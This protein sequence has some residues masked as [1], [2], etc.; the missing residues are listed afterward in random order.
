MRILY[1]A[2]DQR[3]PGTVGGS[4]HVR[5]V[6]EG[7]AALG[8]DVHVAYTPGGDPP[9]SSGV[10]WHAMPPPFGE[11]RFRMALAPRVTRLARTLRPD[12]VVERYHNFGG[13]GIWAALTVGVPS[14]L[15]VNA[16]VV[17]HPGSWKGRLDRAAVFHPLRRWREWQCR[18]AA[19]IVTPT[20]AI[21]P[22]WL[23]AGR[24]LTIEWGA[25][26]ARFHPDAAGR[27]PF[28]RDRGKVVAIFAGAFRAWH[29]AIHLV[30]AI[31]R[32]HARGEH[33]TVAVLVGAGPEL[34]DVREA[35]RRVPGVTVAG[36]LPHED[37]PAV[38]AAADIGVAPFDIG[39][40]AP[41]H[42]DFYWSP[43][44]VFE[45]MAAGLPV[46]A[47]KLP[48]LAALVENGREGLLY[49]A[50]DPG[51]L[52]SGLARLGDAALRRQL[53]SH[54]RTRASAE[55]GWDVHCRRLEAAFTGIVQ[56]ET[57]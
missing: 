17:D 27:V 47:P 28:T 26:T 46:V 43:L 13:E 23:P 7:L 45:Y 1:S 19:L 11:T 12:L 35:A 33:D 54:A 38:L 50:H 29:G 20:A 34:A 25:D 41:L 42:L 31:D 22:A 10:T 40:H 4:T 52:A 57:R 49:D 21:V 48:R 37:M 30:D 36:A 24:V 16:P 15:E 2:A 14:V 8:H 32:L 44:K 53:G 9:E 6:A 39:R 55:Y 3:V 56:G 18:Q 5:A 51:A